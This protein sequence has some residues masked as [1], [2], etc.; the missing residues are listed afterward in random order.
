MRTQQRH[1]ACVV[2]HAF[3]LLER[4]VV[5][6][7][8]A[9]EPQLRHWREQGRARPDGDAQLTRAQTA[10]HAL[11]LGVAEPAVHDRDLVAQAG[12]KAPHQ[13]RRERDLRHKHDGALAQLQRAFGG[14]QIDFGLARSR[15]ALQQEL[16]TLTR[17]QL[18]LDGCDGRRLLGVQLGWHV[19]RHRRARQRVRHRLALFERHEAQLRQSLQRRARTWHPLLEL[20]DRQIAVGQGVEHLL[21]LTSRQRRQRLL[22]GERHELHP[23]P[24]HLCRHFAQLG[25]RRFQQLR[26]AALD[27]RQR[28]L[29]RAADRRNVVLR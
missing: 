10:P 13:L 20:R 21:S 22:L 27:G 8:D 16:C 17:R 3:F 6:L 12:P 7:V 5:L 4:A 28:Q 1:V 24:E 11:P 23:A 9:N 2:A 19:G 14:A 15:H 26:R 18:L 29:D 25:L